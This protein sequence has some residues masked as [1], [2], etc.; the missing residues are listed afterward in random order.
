MSRDTEV[1]RGGLALLEDRTDLGLTQLYVECLSRLWLL[2]ETIGLH[3]VL[4]VLGLLF[5]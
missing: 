2:E 3:G 4:L 5:V 1:E